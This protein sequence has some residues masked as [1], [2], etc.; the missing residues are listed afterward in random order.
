M[1][2]YEIYNNKLIIPQ[3]TIA[4]L[5]D[6]RILEMIENSNSTSST[7]NE[8]NILYHTELKKR[9]IWSSNLC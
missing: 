9:N 6:K 1:Q 7:W 3:E 4:P 5:L 2:G 8:F